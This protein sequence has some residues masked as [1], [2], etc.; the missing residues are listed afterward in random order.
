LHLKITENE[1]KQTYERNELPNPFRYVVK[2]Y[3]YYITGYFP[4][5]AVIKN[6]CVLA[7]YSR[8]SIRPLTQID[9]DQKLSSK[10]I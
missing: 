3:S 10:K 9:T 4:P 1:V 5:L 2:D 6:R 7:R 8:E